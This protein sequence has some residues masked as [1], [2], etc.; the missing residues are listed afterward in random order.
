MPPFYLVWNF[1]PA[2]AEPSKAL[3]EK[4]AFGECTSGFDFGEPSQPSSIMENVITAS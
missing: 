1:D 4:P 3:V 2:G